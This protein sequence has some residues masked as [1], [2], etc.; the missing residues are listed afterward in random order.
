[1]DLERAKEILGA[2]VKRQ[3]KIDGNL[4][5]LYIGDD[6]DKFY[7]EVCDIPVGVKPDGEN[8]SRYAISP[9]WFV[10]KRTGEANINWGMPD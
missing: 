1:M 4:F 8:A 9:P 10:D 6:S 5:L 2:V 7:F 3:Q